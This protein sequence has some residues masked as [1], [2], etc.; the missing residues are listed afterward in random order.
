MGTLYKSSDCPGC[1]LKRLEGIMPT[2]NSML[3]ISFLA[4]LGCVIQIRQTNKKQKKHLQ[5]IK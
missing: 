5:V 3:M 2:V 4:S 1:K